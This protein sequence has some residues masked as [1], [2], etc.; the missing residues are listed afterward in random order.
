MEEMNNLVPDFVNPK[1]VDQ[2]RTKFKHITRLECLLQ[3]FPK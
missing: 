3:D 1:Y 2:T